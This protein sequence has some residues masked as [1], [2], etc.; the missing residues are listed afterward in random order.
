[1]QNDQIIKRVIFNPE[2]SQEKHFLALIYQNPELFD[3]VKDIEDVY[4]SDL[5]GENNGISC[6][7]SG[8][9]QLSAWPT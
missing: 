3:S 1:M 5:H 9:Q 8:F 7:Q 4:F 2:K 6:D